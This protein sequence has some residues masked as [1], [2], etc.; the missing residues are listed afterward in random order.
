MTTPNFTFLSATTTRG[1][2]AS[3]EGADEFFHPT[4]PA[5][6][7]PSNGFL[8]VLNGWNLNRR[9]ADTTGYTGAAATAVE[10]LQM[11]APRLAI[12]PAVSAPGAGRIF[13]RTAFWRYRFRDSRTGEHSG[14]SPIPGQKL[15]MGTEQPV[16][17]T[18]YIG[19]KAFF[20]ILVTDAPAHA[21]TVDLFRC[22]SNRA[23]VVYLVES[24][25]ILGLTYVSF[26]DNYTDEEILLKE[27]VSLDVP[28]G[29]TWAEGIMPP[30]CKAWLHPGGFTFYFGIRRMG[31]RWHGGSSTSVA[32]TQGSDLLTLS[33]SASQ[34]RIVEP[35]RIGQRVLFFATADLTD[36]I[37]DP[38][39]YFLVKCES[40]LTFRIYPEIQVSSELAADATATWYFA[41]VDQ[42]DARETWIGDSGKPWLIP[43]EWVVATGDDY[44]D[45]VMAWFALNGQTYLQTRRRTI[46]VLDD[47][48]TKPWLTMRFAQIAPEGAVGLWA[49]CETPFGYVYVTEKKGVRLFSGSSVGPL[50]RDSGPLSS[51]LAET[52]FERF[53]PSMLEEVRCIYD[54]VGHAVYVAYVPT[55]GS[56]ISEAIVFSAGDG[57]WRGPYRVAF[58]TAGDVRTTSSDN[59]LVVG[60]HYGNLLT[61]D[62]QVLDVVPATGST[63]TTTGTITAVTRNRIFT[64]SGA[65]FNAD[66]DERLRGCPVWFTNAAGTALYFAR[67]ADVLSG[68]QLELDGPPVDEDGAT[69]TL[70]TGWTYSI[71][72]I[73]WEAITACV[74]GGDAALPKRIEE[75]HF[76]FRRGTASTTFEVGCAEDSNGTYAGQRTDAST[77]AV[78]PK[79]VNGTVWARVA[80]E[81]EGA[82][83]QFR[84]RGL[85][86]TGDPK[87]T[88][89]II[90]MHAMT[91]TL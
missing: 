88:N 52:Q 19:Q 90:P 11:R 62:E 71:G 35:G 76:R 86:R 45:G 50:D 83:F 24:K 29:P 44:D 48:S 85:S 4:L 12:V 43:P 75:I 42:R 46:A 10:L 80:L 17:G 39:A 51:F 77:A 69:A 57:V 7:E 55:G 91:G 40:E 15:N 25:S 53:E 79:D 74:D 58:C 18:G 65:T 81:R 13:S 67:I 27:I 78:E 64:D 21:D 87:I 30:M 84:I 32:V 68:T 70:T 82:E 31:R 5:S 36:P 2:I 61:L 59:A 41:I 9:L 38:T 73:R 23:D 63:L 14:L 37:T 28:S 22:G 47:Y 33:A 49:G 54:P 3:G 8:T 66:A 20:H 1:L 26:T 72:A 89:V 6:L 34:P 60:D 56:V 16:G